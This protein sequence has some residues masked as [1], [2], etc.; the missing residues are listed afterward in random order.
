ML[1]RLFYA[2]L[3]ATGISALA[4]RAGRGGAILCYHNVVRVHDAYGEPALHLALDR[5]SRQLRWIDGH[6]TVLPLQEFNAR[7]QAGGAL[8][9]AV[10]ITFDDGY[11]GVF[12]HAW[13][14]L[15]SAGI[16]ATVF[17][18][19]ACID[20]GAP[21]WWDHP[22][23]AQNAIPNRRRHW[24]EELRGDGSSIVRFEKASSTG[25]LPDEYLP[26]T[27]EVIRQAAA[28]GFE[29]G[30]H[31]ATHRNLTRLSAAELDEEIAGSRNTLAQ[32]TGVRAESFA[33]PYGLWN[34]EVHDSVRRAGFRVAVTLDGGLNRAGI[35]PW[36]LRRV[37]IPSS[38][39]MAA[40]EAWAGGLNP[41]VLRLR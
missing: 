6:F 37:N 19:T 23:M 27:W 15:K 18:P 13:P 25:A 30:A 28:E 31:S 22:A 35:D 8:N 5:F 1:S 39:S 11:A 26:A 32:R 41:V 40:F 17:I 20:A 33:Y 7:L 9:R 24:L 12:E 16:P 36:S 10:A 38:I 14:L 34:A 29:L 21:F 3:R 2:G 4:R